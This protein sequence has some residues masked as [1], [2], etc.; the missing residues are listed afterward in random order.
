M[1]QQYRHSAILK[2]L[3][4]L[5][6]LVSIAAFIYQNR[7]IIDSKE[8]MNTRPKVFTNIKDRFVD[9]R[10]IKITVPEGAFNI[11]RQENSE[12]QMYERG[13]YLVSN[14]KIEQ[15]ANEIANIERGEIATESPRQFD[16]LGVGEPLEFGFGTIIELFDSQD[17]LIAATHIGH[18]GDKLFVRKLGEKSIHNAF[19]NLSSIEKVSDWLDFQIIDLKNSKVIKFNSEI[20]SKSKVEI[21]ASN[22]G[23]EFNGVKNDKINALANSINGLEFVDVSRRTKISAEPNSEIKYELSDGGIITLKIYDQFKQHWVA[24][25][26]SAIENANPAPSNVLNEKTKDWVFALSDNS[27]NMLTQNGAKLIAPN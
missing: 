10:R 15:F 4:A 27:Y 9:V 5:T 23:F 14:K 2:I 17:Q 6:L 21:K 20:F 8:L 13:Y 16:E 1:T 25:D 3:L 11:K 26:Y 19:G 22:D 18:N 24:L 7:S 12:W